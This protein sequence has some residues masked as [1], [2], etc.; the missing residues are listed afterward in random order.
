VAD[1]VGEERFF[2]FV[3]EAWPWGATG[4]KRRFA[5]IWLGPEIEQVFIFRLLIQRD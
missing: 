4:M 5:P 1:L 3:N 2:V